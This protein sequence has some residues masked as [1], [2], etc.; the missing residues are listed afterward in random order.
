M[1]ARLERKG[2]PEERQRRGAKAGKR[3][4]LYDFAGLPGYFQGYY[5]HGRQGCQDLAGFTTYAGAPKVPDADG[6]RL[7]KGVMGPH[8]FGADNFSADRGGA[9]PGEFQNQGFFLLGITL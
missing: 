8:G 3:P 2:G 5:R 9:H 4:P 6:I 7:V 1:G